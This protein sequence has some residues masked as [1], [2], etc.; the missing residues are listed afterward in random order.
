MAVIAILF[1]ITI[2]RRHIG[3]IAITT[4]IQPMC[5]RIIVIANR[6]AIKRHGS[7]TDYRY[8]EQDGDQTSW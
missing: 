3:W 8:S 1:A 6:M 5:L 2:I 4:A 7:Y